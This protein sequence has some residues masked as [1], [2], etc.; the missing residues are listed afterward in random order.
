R[1]TLVTVGPAVDA[2][3]RTV[4]VIY[5]VSNTDG[6]LKVDMTADVRIP[7]GPAVPVLLI[8]ASAVL[9][10]AGQSL[11]FV[12]RPPGSYRRRNVATGESRG[13]DMVVRSGLQ[14]GD[15]VVSVG[16]ETLRGELLRGDIPTEEQ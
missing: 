10:G 6:A 3:N 1:G 9:F 8:P 14:P 5:R 11:V 4:P 13:E 2:A 7:K 12:E 16:A 15:R